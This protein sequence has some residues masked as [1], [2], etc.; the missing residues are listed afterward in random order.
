LERKEGP[1]ETKMQI[2][3]KTTDHKGKEVKEK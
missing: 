3:E 1:I 2:I